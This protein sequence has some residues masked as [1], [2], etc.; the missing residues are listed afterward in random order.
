MDL[1]ESRENLNG[2]R[3][4][5]GGRYEIYPVSALT[6]EGLDRLVAGI[7]R[8]LET[9]PAREPEGAGIE[10]GAL[11]SAGPR[12]AV[13]REGG[14]FIVSGREIERHV[15]MTDLENDEAVG[16][17]QR[18]MYLMGVDRALKEAGA[19]NGDTVKIKE[20]EFEYSE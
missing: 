11:H 16:R 14:V 19:K 2:F 10:P 9:I 4:E 18:I 7:A 20:F 3:A 13:S 8:L 17:L 5:L 12:F 1:P 15:T 6:G